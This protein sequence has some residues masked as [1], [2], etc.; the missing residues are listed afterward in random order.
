MPAAARLLQPAALG[1]R[2]IHPTGGERKG[3]PVMSAALSQAA[4]AHP[5]RPNTR[6]S[7]VWQWRSDQPVGFAAL[8]PVDESVFTDAAQVLCPKT[9]NYG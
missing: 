5:A 2:L 8:Q 3:P 9:S 4:R 6:S 7:G 1:D